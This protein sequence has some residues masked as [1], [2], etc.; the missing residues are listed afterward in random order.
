MAELQRT[1][2]RLN[3]EDLVSFNKDTRLDEMDLLDPLINHKRMADRDDELGNEDPVNI[4]IKLGESRFDIEPLRRKRKTDLLQRDDTRPLSFED[5]AISRQQTQWFDEEDL[6][7]RILESDPNY[8]FLQLVAGAANRR[9]MELYDQENLA[10]IERREK[11]LIKEQS[12]LLD[13][14]KQTIRQ[15]EEQAL[16]CQSRIEEAKIKLYATGEKMSSLRSE[17]DKYAPISQSYYNM[18]KVKCLKD[19]IQFVLDNFDPRGTNIDLPQVI[20][21]LYK[22]TKDLEDRL[23]LPPLP[24]KLERMLHKEIDDTIDLSD[25]EE[26][27]DE[28]DDDAKLNS[29]DMKQLRDKNKTN[30][31]IHLVEITIRFLWDFILL[32]Y[33]PKENDSLKLSNDREKGV[34][35][36]IGRVHVD[37]TFV[38][39]KNG[40]K[41]KTKFLHEFADALIL[42]IVG[43]VIDQTVVFES[44]TSVVDSIAQL[45]KLRR[46]HTT[47]YIETIYKNLTKITCDGNE[48]SEIKK[49]LRPTFKT[50]STISHLRSVSGEPIQWALILYKTYLETDLRQN[51][52][53]LDDNVKQLALISKKKSDQLTGIIRVKDVEYPYRHPIQ[54]ISRPEHSGTV[55]L[56]PIVIQSLSE[57]YKK[58]RLYCSALKGASI[59]DLQNCEDVRSDFAKLVAIQISFSAQRAPKQYYN[60]SH[61]KNTKGEE[62]DVMQRLKYKYKVVSVKDYEG[63][64]TKQV[65]L[66]GQS[67]DSEFGSSNS[68]INNSYYG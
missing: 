17:L 35:D 21:R 25:D 60:D 11:F 12:L 50:M 46:S 23:R 9:V 27:E 47:T 20:E 5:D 59:E 13:Q 51:N 18:E 55:L 14:T 24:V 44:D 19:N 61:I 41:I 42:L 53:Y 45:N 36:I 49:A 57:A 31:T 6:L 58:V 30:A 7:N 62:A 54:W 38:I 52:G 37:P 2:R 39:G 8:Q 40:D 22:I 26:D 48:N 43:E 4:G 29:I 63:N 56:T 64:V 67:Y 66:N 1:L 3:N 68:A 32:H 28:D 33:Y 65:L 34:E 15:L 16:K 10:T